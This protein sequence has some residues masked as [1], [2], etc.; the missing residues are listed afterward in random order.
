MSLSCLPASDKNFSSLGGAP[1]GA[2]CSVQASNLPVFTMDFSSLGSSLE[3]ATSPMI[4]VDQA[5]ITT[6]ELKFPDFAQIGDVSK[7]PKAEAVAVMNKYRAL[8]KITRNKMRKAMKLDPIKDS[9][10]NEV[11]KVII[12]FNTIQA[13]MVKICLAHQLHFY[14]DEEVIPL[15]Q[16]PAASDRPSRDGGSTGQGDPIGVSGNPAV[17]T[18]GDSMD[19]DRSSTA[20]KRPLETNT[21]GLEDGYTV[22]SNKKK[23]SKLNR[24]SGEPQKGSTA[25]P[26]IPKLNIPPIFIDPPKHWPMLLTNLEIQAPG[27]KNS[28]AGRFMK[29]EFLSADHFRSVQNYLI[30]SKIQFRTYSLDDDKPIKAVIRGLPFKTETEDIKNA[31]HEEGFLDVNVTQMYRGPVSKKNYMPLFHVTLAKS[32]EAGNIF[33]LNSIMGASCKV[34]VYKGRKGPSQCYNCQ[35]FFHSAKDCH[36]APACCKCAQKHSS[37]DCTKQYNE[38]CTC[39]NCGEAHPA[40]FRQCPKFPK[41]SP[42]GNK[43]T[44][45]PPAASAPA[46]TFNSKKA[47]ETRSFSGVVAG[48]SVKQNPLPQNS[49]PKNSVPISE[50]D[51][52]TEFIKM[53][54]Q[55]SEKYSEILVHKAYS[56]ALPEL[57]KASTAVDRIF[58]LFTSITKMLK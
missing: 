22:V 9:N 20:S 10:R 46:R 48:Q 5:D 25:T 23:V 38:P 14:D 13:D 47:D 12:A 2:S 24:A 43:I 58:I 8:Q 45:K 3:G 16:V 31:L 11:S 17:L 49:E 4:A 57:R 18:E 37:R 53:I 56:N 50:A 26:R 15:K 36:M 54:I 32:P 52:A 30:Q 27:M 33:N 34:E 40:N 1:E 44:K 21:A 41:S 28:N 19:V 7:I 35:G 39:V 29:L 51:S 42:K 6:Y 55:F